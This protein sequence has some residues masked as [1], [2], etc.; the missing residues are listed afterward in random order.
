MLPGCGPRAH[1]SLAVGVWFGFV[2]AKRGGRQDCH[3]GLVLIVGWGAWDGSNTAR[4]ADGWPVLP[5][6]PRAH[7][8]P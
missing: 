8:R 6:T 4:S 7:G 1:P 3:F 5:A 2:L